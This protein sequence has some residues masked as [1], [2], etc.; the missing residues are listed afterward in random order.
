MTQEI[1]RKRRKLNIKPIISESYSLL[2]YL[3]NYNVFDIY[4]AYV[5]TRGYILINYTGSN[6]W[7][8]SYEINKNPEDLYLNY[9]NLN[10]EDEKILNKIF[11]GI[12]EYLKPYEYYLKK[13][14]KKVPHEIKEEIDSI[15][16]DIWDKLIED[17]YIKNDSD[18]FVKVGNYKDIQM[19]HFILNPLETFNTFLDIEGNG[20]T[21][22]DDEAF[23]IKLE[24]D[25]KIEN[26]V[27]WFNSKQAYYIPR[28]L[29][30][31]AIQKDSIF[32]PNDFYES[33]ISMINNVYPSHIFNL[34]TGGKKLDKTEGALELIQLFNIKRTL[35]NENESVYYYNEKNNYYEEITEK[36]LKNLIYKEYGFN[37]VESDIKAI[38]KSIPSED[39][40]YK[41]IL[42]F[43]NCL[44][45]TNTLEKVTGIYNRRDYLTLNRIGYK[46]KNSNKINLLDFDEYEKPLEVE[47]ILTVKELSEAATLTERTLREILIPKTNPNDLSLYQD[48]LERTGAKI[49]GRN[50]FKDITFYDT[51]YSNAGKTILLYLL[52]LLYNDKN[53]SID[54][55]TLED[56]FS[57]KSYD[58]AL[59]I[60]IDEIDKDSFEKVKP[61]L[62]RIS[63]QYSK[64]QFRNM[65]EESQY[66]IEEFSEIT[67]CS[68]IKLNL[69]PVDDYALFERIDFLR[70]PNRFVSEHEVKKYDNAYIKND[71]LFNELRKDRRGLN[72]LI[73]ASIK[74]FK[75][76]MKNK[77]RYSCKQTA[78]QSIDIYTDGNMILKF[79][80]VYTKKDS[81]LA[82]SDYVHVKDIKEQFLR[83]L[84]LKGLSLTQHELNNLSQSIGYELAKL[85]DLSK[86]NGKENDSKGVKYSIELKNLEDVAIEFRQIYEI[87]EDL[88]NQDLNNLSYLS[89]D[90]KEIY[91]AIKLDG[92]NT[93][94]LLKEIYISYDVYSCIKTLE[95][96]SLIVNTGKTNLDEY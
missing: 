28:T 66:I 45:D 84:E 49:L 96:K 95:E 80:V 91:N 86:G 78:E 69:D 93:I 21:V 40:L 10:A 23:N 70:L 88:S 5:K 4:L 47:D 48:Y 63:S 30:N 18:S 29:N 74:C 34:K 61:T 16:L 85:Y 71:N 20:Y 12:K 72:W 6:Y 36:G 87:N 82:I 41:N 54:A 53:I 27:E 11:D 81:D 26:L 60:N 51:E 64:Q 59:A 83:Y 75:D 25:E 15:A 77:R 55:S 2:D 65:R 14:L 92:K 46:E 38:F 39:K 35:K 9:G 13:E 42:A 3:P 8:K 62:K 67:I 37:L 68:N 7:F 90:E 24:F 58:N 94:N 89:S 19:K 17:V 43:N 79:L 52:D 56:N 33:V 32:K 76:M 73:T 22:S 50:L 57:F 1:K 31:G 44:F